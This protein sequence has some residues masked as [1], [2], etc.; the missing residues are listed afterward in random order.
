MKTIYL[1]PIFLFVSPITLLL[2]FINTLTVHGVREILDLWGDCCISYINV[3]HY[4]AHLK[5]NIQCQL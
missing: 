3:E 4:A 1:V 5:H 2:G